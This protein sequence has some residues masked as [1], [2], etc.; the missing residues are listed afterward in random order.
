MTD[1]QVKKLI[2]SIETGLLREITALFDRRSIQPPMAALHLSIMVAHLAGPEAAIMSRLGAR[3][4]KYLNEAPVEED[5]CE[6]DTS[7]ARAVMAKIMRG[8]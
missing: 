2:P 1:D 5:D 8:R 7:E 6:A 3:V 4:C